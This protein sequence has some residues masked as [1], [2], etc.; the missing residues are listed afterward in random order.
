MVT[1]SIL[2]NILERL[3]V[4]SNENSVQLGRHREI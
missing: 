3:N 4:N 2:I 1:I